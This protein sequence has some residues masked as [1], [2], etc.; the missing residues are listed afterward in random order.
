M[1]QRGIRLA[2]HDD[3]LASAI[4]DT[5]A[6]NP[7]AKRSRVELA[8]ELGGRRTFGEVNCDALIAAPEVLGLKAQSA[9]RLIE[10]QVSR[11]EAQANAL[12]PEIETENRALMRYQAGLEVTQ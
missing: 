3:L 5:R 4:Y 10:E 6:F 12:L 1:D 11:I 8:W 9:R 7:E 2:P